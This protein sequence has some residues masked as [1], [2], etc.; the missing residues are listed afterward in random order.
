MSLESLDESLVIL[1]ELR[2][3]YKSSMKKA[4]ESLQEKYKKQRKT[5]ESIGSMVKMSGADEATLAI[6]HRR[7]HTVTLMTASLMLD[8]FDETKS[9]FVKMIV[10]ELNES[11]EVLNGKPLVHDE[12]IDSILSQ[13]FTSDF[14]YQM[15]CAISDICD[16][17]RNQIGKSYNARPDLLMSA[18]HD[19]DEMFVSDIIN[20]FEKS[21]E[22]LFVDVVRLTVRDKQVKCMTVSP[23]D[24]TTKAECWFVHGT[25]INLTNSFVVHGSDCKCV[26]LFYTDVAV[27]DVKSIM[28]A[29]EMF[30]LLPT[31]EAK[32]VLGDEKYAKW[33]KGDSLNVLLTVDEG[34]SKQ[35]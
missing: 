8:K 9:S 15:E 24:V 29:D 28:Q 4:V 12:E 32:A 34:N 30:E 18:I 23:C 3:E 35:A 19:A 20:V 33:L 2:R 5:L 26:P 1:T 6:L 7:L 10:E 22:N 25:D 17:Q 16:S 31:H 13:L 27:D 11:S 21:V 14:D